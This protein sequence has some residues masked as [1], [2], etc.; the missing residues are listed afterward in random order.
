MTTKKQN[1]L[2]VMVRRTLAVATLMSVHGI[3]AAESNVLDELVV[4]AT[5]EPTPL[6]DVAA[7]VA[8]VTQ[9]DMSDRQAID[10]KES[11][12]RVPGVDFYGG[13]RPQAEQPSVRAATGKQLAVLL[14]GARQNAAPGFVSPVH[15][16]PIFLSDVQVLKG[17]SS[18]LYGAGAIGGTIS[19]RT[20]SPRELLSKGDTLAADVRA[21][22]QSAPDAPRGAVRAYGSAG[23]F[24]WLGGVSYRTWGEIEQGGDHVLKPSDGD[25]TNALLK[26]EWRMSDRLSLTASYLRYQSEDFRP[27]NPQADATFPYMQN[28]RIDQDTVTVGLRGTDSGGKEDLSLSVYLNKFKMGADA[29]V[30]QSLAESSDA[31]ET[32]GLTGEKN[33]SFDTGSLAHRLTIGGDAYRDTSTA[34]SGGQPSTV[35]PD[36]TQSVAGAFVRDAMSLGLFT[37]TP[38]VRFDYYKSSVDSGVASD[39]T[40]NHFSPQ[41]T[42]AVRPVDGLLVHATYGEAFRAP[43]IAEMFQSLSGNQWFANFRPNPNL[44]PE[45]SSD[46]NLGVAWTAMELIADG[47]LTVRADAFSAKVK[48]LITSTTVGT[49]FNPFLNRNRP[50]LQSVNVGEAERKGFEV[51]ADLEFSS[52][53]FT[54]GYSQVRSKDANTGD[55]LFAPPDKWMVGIDYRIVDSLEVRWQ[56]LFVEAQDYDS[57]VARRRNSYDVHDAFVTWQPGAGRLRVDLGVTN[58]FDKT[59]VAYK[60]STAYLE[61]YEEGRSVRL[62]I[63]ASF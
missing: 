16:D 12:E 50:I 36:G 1:A 61:T 28:N 33:L 38:A 56:S 27:N 30:A 5:R 46:I 41:L 13:P 42:L 45:E 18:A 31:M 7:P 19:F 22:Y 63:G 48:N 60:Q 20:A 21:D 37:V 40:E 62:G 3:A 14:D 32:L 4:T 24:Y 11:L 26:G 53:G 29:N 59:Y 6:A 55:N 17:A 8:V 47:S 10:F 44:E 57:T 43:T 51:Q 15:V 9:D 34:L 49:F 2:G 23:E 25:A 58:L 35:T 52:V 54:A 39:S